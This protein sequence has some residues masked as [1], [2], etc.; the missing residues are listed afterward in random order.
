MIDLLQQLAVEHVL[1]PIF[2]SILT[3]LIGWASVKWHQWTGKQ[4][5]AAHRQALQS[6]LENGVRFALQRL[7]EANPAADPARLAPEEKQ[8]VTDQA[9]SYVRTSVPDAVKHFKLAEGGSFALDTLR[10]LILPKLPLPT[11]H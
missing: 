11:D 3:A 1:L 6:A 8:L 10:K 7:M 4:I 5:E 2:A 9:I